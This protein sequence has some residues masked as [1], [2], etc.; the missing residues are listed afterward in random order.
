MS[1]MP[2]SVICYAN[3]LGARIEGLKTSSSQCCL[4]SC[5]SSSPNDGKEIYMSSVILLCACECNW[6]QTGQLC[7]I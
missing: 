2:L 4:L 7:S 6:M 5:S 1:L 3:A